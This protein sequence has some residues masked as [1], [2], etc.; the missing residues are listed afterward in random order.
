MPTLTDL[1]HHRRA[2]LGPAIAHLEPI[3]NNWQI[4][5]LGYSPFVAFRYLTFHVRQGKIS[6]G[7]NYQPYHQRGKYPLV[8][9]DLLTLAVIYNPLGLELNPALEQEDPCDS[10]H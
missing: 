7:T 3:Q 4:D 6:W 9:I 1:Y 2:S 5:L 8:E 10:S